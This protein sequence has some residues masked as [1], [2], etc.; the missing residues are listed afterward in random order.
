MPG[1]NPIYAHQNRVIKRDDLDMIYV[2]GPGAAAP[3]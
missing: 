1:L 2:C 3:G